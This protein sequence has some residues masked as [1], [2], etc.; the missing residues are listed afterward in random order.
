MSNSLTDTDQQ[1]NLP[2]IKLAILNTDYTVPLHPTC[3]LPVQ[4]QTHSDEDSAASC[5]DNWI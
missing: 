1:T 5:V 3:Y 2:Y 4:S